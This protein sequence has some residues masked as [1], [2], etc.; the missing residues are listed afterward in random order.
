M[1]ATKEVIVLYAM[2]VLMIYIIYIYMVI[3]SSSSGHAY[4]KVHLGCFSDSSIIEYMETRLGWVN[5]EIIGHKKAYV[6]S[7]LE[8]T[9]GILHGHQHICMYGVRKKV[10]MM[11]FLR[12]VF[13]HCKTTW[14]LFII[15]IGW[16][17]SFAQTPRIRLH[18]QNVKKIDRFLWV[19]QG[20]RFTPKMHVMWMVSGEV[21]VIDLFNENKLLPPP[22]P[23]LETCMCLI[24]IW[25]CTHL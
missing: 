23:L 11:Y 12:E 14:M 2:G 24:N 17:Y 15:W 20:S 4:H 10:R 5:V 13:L 8:C 9:V 21:G 19:L 1:V 22:I 3:Y 16:D 18:D 6:L 7:T 25:F